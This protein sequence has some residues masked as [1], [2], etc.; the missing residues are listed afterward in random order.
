METGV[1]YFA[2]RDLRHVKSDLVAMRKN[3]CSYVVHTF[4]EIDLQY[5]KENMRQIVAASVEAGL[6][7]RIDPW[8]VA[9]LFGGEAY[10]YFVADKLE[11]RQIV[12][13]GRSVPLACPNNPQARLFLRRWMDEVVDLGAKFIFWDEPHFYEPHWVGDKDKKLWGCKCNCCQNSFKERFNRKMPDTLTDEIEDFKQQSLILFLKE[14]CDYSSS[15]GLKNSVCLLPN[16]KHLEGDFWDEVAEIKSLDNIG[17]D[18]Y[19]VEIKK[20]ERNFN[21]DN[22]IRKFCKKIN[23][24]SKSHKK[25]GHIWIQNFSIPS[26]WEGDIKT[27]ADIAYEEGIRDIAAWSYY[28]TSCMSSKAC[29]SPELVW[30]VLGKSYKELLSKE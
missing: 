18:P 19:W 1:S 9:G 14:L 29:D 6:E 20:T 12:S 8:G 5:Y 30:D 23:H 28:G 13:D 16:A 27:V 21:L 17:T 25:E 22:Y 7:V 26:G 2:N 4:S 15:K 24:L 3:H 11:T 10:S